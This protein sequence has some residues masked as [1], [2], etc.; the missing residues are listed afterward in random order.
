MDKLLSISEII[1]L[2]IPNLPAT[3]VGMRAF[4]ER[5]GWPF[6]NAT[7]VGGTKR[8][9]KL[10]S[11]YAAHGATGSSEGGVVG[12]TDVAGYVVGGSS[13]VD[14]A[15]LESAIRALAEW[16][17]EKG[18]RVSDERRPAVIAILYDYAQRSFGTDGGSAMAVVLRALA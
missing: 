4:A 16:E 5:E 7:G 1:A 11:K 17:A 14:P 9:Y 2:G 15:M 10:P 13:Q 18:I 3:K 8:L 12:P 6:E